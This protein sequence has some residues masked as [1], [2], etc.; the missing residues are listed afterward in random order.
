MG[1]LEY[2][3]FR[4]IQIGHSVAYGSPPLQR[5]SSVVRSCVH[6]K[7]CWVILLPNIGQ[8]H[9]LPKKI[10]AFTQYFMVQTLLPKI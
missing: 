10:Q 1:G 2:D 6:C 3:S 8:L 5:F 7:F 4:A 9:A